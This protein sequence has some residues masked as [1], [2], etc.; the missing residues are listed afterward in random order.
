VLGEATEP[1]RALAADE[2]AR[3]HAAAVAVF[4]GEPAVVAVYLHGSAARGQPAADLD[5]ALLCEGERLGFARLDRLAADLQ[6]RA[7]VAGLE[8]DLRTLDGATPRFAA[9]VL[10]DGVVLF[11]RDGRRRAHLEAR[12]M[13]LW[14]DFQPT[15]ERM[16]SRMLARWIDG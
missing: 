13:V 14:T 15:W 12:I 1:R 3:L 2:L 9:N 6:T 11:D 16:R 7:G 8:I 10:R 4:A 5:I